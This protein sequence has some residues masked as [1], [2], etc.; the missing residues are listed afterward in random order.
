MFQIN[1]KKA[2]LSDGWA[3]N[4]LV[5][6]SNEGKI[7]K[8]I[9]NY[10][11]SHGKNVGI[12]LP[13]PVNVHSHSFQRAIAGLTE[14]RGV[15][16][17]DSFWTWRELMFKFLKHL[18][19]EDIESISTFVQM[20][21]LE[22]GFSSVVEFHYLHHQ[23]NGQPY[24][25][26][27]ELSE[28]IV[29]SSERSG[30]GLTFLPVHYQYGG[31]D[32]RGLTSGQVRF[33]ND[34][35]RFS[36]LAEKCKNLISKLSKDHNFGIAVHSLRSVSVDGINENIKL[37]ANNPFHIHLAEQTAEVSEVLNFYGQRP[38]EF[39]VDNFPVKPNW[40]LIHCTQMNDNENI[41]LS[42]TGAVIGLCPLTE[43]NLGDGIFEA[44]KWLNNNGSI[45]IGSDSNIQISLSDE[46]KT[47]EYSQRLR[48]KTRASLANFEKSSGRR[49]FDEILAGGARAS[50][51]QTG[52]IK[53]ENW[54]DLMVLDE[55]SFD[56]A[57]VE[58]DKII[59]KFVFV[60]GTKLV[61]DVWS[62]GRH[63][64]KEGKHINRD[65]I[66]RHYNKTI[67]NLGDR[68]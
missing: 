57:F 45:A 11:L 52:S 21:M 65:Q 25:N 31:C 47:L 59:D 58:E 33:G 3:K 68:I 62:A 53:E 5:E 27:S 44:F 10:N 55:D 42:K 61:T 8:V 16:D 39:V 36:L 60:S 7:S 66:I 37:C 22:A 51:R 14:N 2:L 30:I 18:N 64:V 49:I 29:S 50:N 38:I 15:Y 1:A 23:P 56:L 4:V 63:V 9:K 54:A 26:L 34:I 67:S 46:I 20:Q 32:K 12:L 6:I 17:K 28:R 35:N 43:A 19:P 41:L 13:S 48:D 40:C 24:N